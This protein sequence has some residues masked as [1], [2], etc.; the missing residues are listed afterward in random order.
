MEILS[1]YTMLESNVKDVFEKGKLSQ[2]RASILRAM[3]VDKVKLA[4][5][6]LEDEGVVASIPKNPKIQQILLDIESKKSTI[7]AIDEKLVALNHV[8]IC[9]NC[10][11]EMK[12]TEA[13]CSACGTKLPENAVAKKEEDK[14]ETIDSSATEIKIE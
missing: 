14:S 4:D 13:F 8:K 7:R 2:D 5:A 1:K 10:G 3:D 9:P 12:D 6:I 11:K